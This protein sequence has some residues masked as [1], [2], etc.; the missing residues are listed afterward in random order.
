M[1]EPIDVLR[2]AYEEERRRLTRLQKSRPRPAFSDMLLAEM[3]VAQ[4]KAR[5]DEAAEQ[6][7]RWCC[8]LCGEQRPRNETSCPC[9]MEER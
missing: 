3:R 5:L 6:A 2:A 8:P 1:I 9:I 4:T 7:A